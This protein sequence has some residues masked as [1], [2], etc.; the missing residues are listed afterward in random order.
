MHTLYLIRHAKSDWS[1]RSLPDER[2]PL[3]RRGRRDARQL[4]AHLQRAR[5][6]PDL[7]LC[8]TAERTRET[9]QLLLTALNSPDVQLE[10]EL[11]GASVQILLDRLHNVAQNVTSVMLIGHNPGLQ[12]L[13][14]ALTAPG[15]K[16]TLVEL[17]FPTAAL[18]TIALPTTSWTNLHEGDA[19]LTEYV[20]PKQLRT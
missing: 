4:A 10:R 17:K 18:A 3:N 13:A 1:N 20:T 15:T 16:R 11:Y 9:L 19:H 6:E 12:E 2:R 5:I 14:I 8:S 7:I